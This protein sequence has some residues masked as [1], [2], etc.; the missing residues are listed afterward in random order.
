[1]GKKTHPLHIFQFCPRCGSAHFVEKDEM[2]KHCLDCHFVYYFNISASC[3][4][5]IVNDKG[6]LMVCKRAKEPAKGTLDL[7][8]GFISINETGEEGIKREI[9]EETGL[10]IEECTYLFSLPNIYPYAGFE[11]HTLDAFYRCSVP[12]G[13][14]VQAQD[15]VEAIY[16]IPIYELD[17]ARFGLTSIRKAITRFIA[18]IQKKE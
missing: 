6:E 8:G 18:E 13:L 7:P 17:P 2:A 11:V 1:M 12:S 15:D 14:T 9:H 4:A 5:F 3:A 16:W 10:T